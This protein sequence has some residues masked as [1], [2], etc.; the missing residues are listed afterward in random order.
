MKRG[1]QVPNFHKELD[2]GKN[3]KL[4]EWL[5]AELLDNVAGLFRAFLKGNETILADYL[6]NIVI[7]TYALA[8]RLGIEYVEI[9]KQ[10]MEK[11]EKNVQISATSGQLQE[12]LSALATHIR[13]R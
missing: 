7:V 13:K 10:I 5:K 4:M 1:A 12:D 11:I 9:D 3:I 8:K 6:T 2:I